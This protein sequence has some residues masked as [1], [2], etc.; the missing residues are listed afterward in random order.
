MSDPR[1]FVHAYP[2]F[3]NILL[4]DVDS[5]SQDKGFFTLTPQYDSP[6]PEDSCHDVAVPD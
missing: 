3:S 2:M 6:L 4:A 5:T 1:A